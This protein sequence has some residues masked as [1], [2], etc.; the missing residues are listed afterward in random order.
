MAQYRTYALS[1]DAQGICVSHNHRAVSGFSLGGTAAWYVFLQRMEAFRWFLPIS[2]ASWDDGEG[3]ISGIWNSDLSAQTLYDAVLEQGYSK[4]DFSNS[5]FSYK[6]ND[7][8]RYT[9]SGRTI[10]SA[11]KIYVDPD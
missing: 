10:A 11:V 4:R 9:N 6:T 2:E 1:T 5:S 8:S 3:S 7:F